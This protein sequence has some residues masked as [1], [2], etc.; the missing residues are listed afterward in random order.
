[1]KSKGRVSN[2]YSL[3]SCSGFDNEVNE[4]FQIKLDATFLIIFY[5][6]NLIF[7][8]TIFDDIVN[9]CIPIERTILQVLL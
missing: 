8:M 1:M 5:T 7:E 3:S 4:M 9:N 6:L 2:S